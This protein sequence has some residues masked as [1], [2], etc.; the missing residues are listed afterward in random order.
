MSTT[1]DLQCPQCLMG[2]CIDCQEPGCPGPAGMVPKKEGGAACMDG[3]AMEILM[4]FCL[5]ICVLE[6]L[7]VRAAGLGPGDEEGCAFLEV[8]REA[9]RIVGKKKE[10][11]ANG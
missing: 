1:P 6:N 5:L 7:I 11:R 9:R 2:T 8:L 4:T 3:A 10:G